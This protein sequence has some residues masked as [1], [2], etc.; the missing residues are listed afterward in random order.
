[1]HIQDLILLVIGSEKGQ[2][3][4]G[5]TLLQKKLYFLSVLKEIDL[6]FAPHYYGPYS[7]LVAE[8]LDI[9]VSARFLNEVTETFETDRN[10]FDEIRR[11]TY[12]LTPDG[13]TI[14]KEIQQEAEYTDW[15]QTLDTLNSQPLASDFNTLSIAAKV[16]Y[17]VNRQGR[18]TTEQ[19][20]E[21]AKEYDWNIDDSQIDNVRSFLEDLSLISVGKPT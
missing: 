3:L 19:I 11:H 10:I 13:D 9:L 12:Y 15:K 8:N 5:R 4:Q 17:I 14:M 2:S 18:T 1:M 16:Y 6:G 21:V 7:S 20:Q